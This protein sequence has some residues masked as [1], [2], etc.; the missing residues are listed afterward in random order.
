M[1][2]FPMLLYK[3]SKVDQFVTSDVMY[4]KKITPT[5]TFG[6]NLNANKSTNRWFVDDWVSTKGTIGDKLTDLGKA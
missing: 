2:N 3:T 1:T 4:E 6:Y 5:T